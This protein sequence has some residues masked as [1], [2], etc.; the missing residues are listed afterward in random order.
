MQVKIGQI[1]EPRSTTTKIRAIEIVAVSG[2]IIQ[3]MQVEGNSRTMRGTS[4][5]HS[6]RNRYTLRPAL[7]DMWWLV[8]DNSDE[9]WKVERIPEWA[10]E[11]L[12]PVKNGFGFYGVLLCDP[13]ADRIQCHICGK[14]YKFLGGHVRFHGTTAE[15]YKDEFELG[16]IGLASIEYLTRSREHAIEIGLHDHVKDNLANIN[17]KT[18]DQRPQS[19][20]GALMTGRSSKKDKH[21]KSV[22]EAQKRRYQDPDQLEARKK[23][24]DEIRSIATK[25]LTGRARTQDVKDAIAEKLK[26][27]KFSNQHKARL[28]ESAKKRVRKSNEERE[29]EILSVLEKDPRATYAKVK[30][31]TGLS[32]GGIGRHYKRMEREGKIRRT[33][34]GIL[35]LD[36]GK[37]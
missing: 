12:E 24:L 32:Y 27:R 10:H 11:K 2:D 35:I 37:E 4:M 3:W 14:W 28:S 6:F 21:R 8:T 20:R 17:P 18:R 1:W 26:G 36:G 31:A 19:L 23:L 15:D 25:K 33:H 13:Y 29:R 30:A 5:L 16:R 34:K 22:S 7:E 9:R